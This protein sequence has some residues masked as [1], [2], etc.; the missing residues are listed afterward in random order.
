MNTT[1]DISG[2]NRNIN[3]F[4]NDMI[5]E[6]LSGI[7]DDEIEN[8]SVFNPFLFNNQR[9]TRSNFTIGRNIQRDSPL[10]D[11][12]NQLFDSSM[13]I[14]D[15]NDTAN[16]NNTTINEQQNTT[17]HPIIEEVTFHITYPVNLTGQ[18][19]NISRNI[20]HPT[21]FDN[22]DNENNDDNIENNNETTNQTINNYNNNSI[23]NRRRNILGNLLHSTYITPL[24]PYS[25]SLERILTQS[26]YDESAYKKKI[27]DK[28][29]QQMCHIKFDKNDTINLNTSCPIMQT[30]FEEDDYIIRLPCN[31]C[32]TPFAINK[33]LDEKPECPVCRYELD[34]VEVKREQPIIQYDNNYNNNNRLRYTSYY[35]HINNNNINDN[36]IGRLPQLHRSNTYARR[37]AAAIALDTSNVDTSNIVNNEN[38][39]N[40][41]NISDNNNNSARY[42]RIWDNMYNSWYYYCQET[43]DTTWNLPHGESWFETNSNNYFLPQ[44]RQFHHRVN[45][46][47][48]SYI[49]YIYNDNDDDFQRALILSYRELSNT[50]VENSIAQEEKNEINNDDND[51]ISISHDSNEICESSSSIDESLY[52]GDDAN[53]TS[54]DDNDSVES[55]NSN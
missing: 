19:R 51:D 39:D 10:Y 42:E 47:P 50:R 16:Q 36:E 26:L 33:W 32:F 7:D 14:F 28:G 41:Q 55:D 9:A 25:N 23:F 30:D 6:L 2:N 18:N 11:M 22:N 53:D 35:T 1:N 37:A 8:P 48:Q 49:D 52:E 24:Q 44:N 46:T 17:E 27:S 3:T 31:H 34:S 45:I 12:V 15:R 54:Y 40:S 5:N 13:N 43:G 20:D 4:L 38:T 21:E 29:K